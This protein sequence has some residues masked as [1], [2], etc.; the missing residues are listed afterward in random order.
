[1]IRNVIFSCLILSLF[2]V[3][4][5]AANFYL[6][7][8]PG[9]IKNGY[10]VSGNIVASDLKRDMS[11]S[12]GWAKLHTLYELKGG[13]VWENLNDSAYCPSSANIEETLQFL[14]ARFSAGIPLRDFIPGYFPIRDNSIRIY[15]YLGPS[16]LKLGRWA[17]EPNFSIPPVTPE[18]PRCTTII[19]PNINFDN[20]VIG[21]TKKISVTGTIRCDKDTTVSVSLKDPKDLTAKNGVLKLSDATVLYDVDNTGITKKYSTRKNINEPFTLNFTLSDTGKIE[22]Q[23]TGYLIL[24]IESL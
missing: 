4:A 19:D 3:R 6:T 5:M 23:K 15:C 21:A 18:T 9:G 8:D 2:L 10:I 13:E 16:E 24:R 14:N 11:T 17:I 1:M 22:A 20:V 12:R 7:P